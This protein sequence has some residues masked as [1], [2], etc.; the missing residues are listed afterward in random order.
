MTA[1][2]DRA[3]ELLPG[4]VRERD[5]ERGR[6]VEALFA[7]LASQGRLVEDDFARLYDDLFI[8]TCDAWV[9]PYLGDLLGVRGLENTGTSRFSGRA[10][11]A[12][13][14]AYRRRKGTATM[15]EQLAF[16]ATGWR[17]RVV[18][19]FEL[20]ATTQWLNHVR[21]HSPHT[22]DLR[23]G[24]ALERIGTA[25]E[26]TRHFVDVRRIARGRGRYNLPNV[27][28]FLWRLDSDYLR[29]R[30][31]LRVPGTGAARGRFLVD[32]LGGELPLF[33]RPQ[34]E[35]EIAALA[36]ELN[37]PAPLRRRPLAEELDA[38]RRAIV[39]GRTPVARW[40][41]DN[42]VFTVE[43]RRAAGDAFAA[44]PPEQV[45]VADLSEPDPP[46][47][48]GW[49][50]PPATLRYLRERDGAQVDAPVA[51]AVDPVLGRIAFPAGE[52]PVAVR[53]SA[54]RGVP[55]DVGGGAYDR[56]ESVARFER[57][58]TLWHAAV[59]RELVA[60]P[61]ARLFATFEDAVAA[62][63]ARPAGSTGIISIVDSASYLHGGVSIQFGAGSRLLVVSAD[64]PEEEPEGAPPRRVPGRIDPT[65]RWSHLVGEIE[66]RSGEGAELWFD[67]LLVEGDLV[68]ANT[69]GAGLEC[70]RLAHCTIVPGRGRLVVQDAHEEV[71][72]ELHRCI[73]GAIEIAAPARSLR[74]DESAVDATAPQAIEAGDVP[75]CIRGSTIVGAAR[76]RELEA[77]DSIFYQPVVVERRQSGCVRFSYVSEGSSTPRRH[78]CQPDLALEGAG[79]SSQADAVLARMVPDFVDEAYGR[80]AYLQLTRSTPEEIRAGA[81][82]GAEMGVWWFL[83]QPQ[84]EANLRAS[85]DEY[86]RLGL[87]AGPIFV[88]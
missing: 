43:V 7:L 3:F 60:D 69:G 24:E 31:A 35:T 44:I 18:E 40:F 1:T 61:A 73:A 45:V 79:T 6:V 29:R 77:S 65:G 76:V 87:E 47:P 42:E 41:G 56:R 86:L 17:A 34:T 64:W 26:E 80:P 59:G 54:A 70:L 2:S 48:E 9:V 83:R 37:V 36:T 19:L 46:R 78:R 82:D 84:R 74:I 57:A 13:T 71:A 23:R 11:V 15:L 33:N 50:R 68:L 5:L 66:V 63:N 81:S 49:L 38:R 52:V 39:N 88:T 20:L 25:F 16:D 8:E 30:D 28:I 58:T 4:I 55:G 32:P 67:G 62:W 53:V 85:L 12:N 51:V 22:P 72:V 27:G 21:L 14:L 10:R 75:A